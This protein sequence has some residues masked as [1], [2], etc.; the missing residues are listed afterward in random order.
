MPIHPAPDLGSNGWGRITTVIHYPSGGQNHI[1]HTGDNAR[2]EGL[3]AARA[4]VLEGIQGMEAGGGDT[5]GKNFRGGYSQYG[6]SAVD[7]SRVALGGGV[8]HVE[9][10]SPF[11][12]ESRR[13]VVVEHQGHSF[14]PDQL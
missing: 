5:S 4:S 10:K 14:R 9:G 13:N 8:I 3:L 1:T 12:P 11:H 2:N 6:E 7:G